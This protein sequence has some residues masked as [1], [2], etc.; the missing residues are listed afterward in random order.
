MR[1][2]FTYLILH[3]TVHLGVKPWQELKTERNL[4]VATEAEEAEEAEVA[5]VPACTHGLFSQPAQGWYCLQWGWPLE[6]QSVSNKMFHRLTCQSGG[7]YSVESPSTQV[8]LDLCQDD[9]NC[10]R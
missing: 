4:M 8:C 3:V 6:H 1:R 5:E 7:G 10:G 2:R 9:K